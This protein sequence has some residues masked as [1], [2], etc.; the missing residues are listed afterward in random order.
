MQGLPRTMQVN[1]QYDDV[2]AEVSGFLKSRVDDLVAKGLDRQTL[3]IDPGIGFG[4]TDEH[5]LQLLANLKSLA[6]LGLPVVVGLSRKSFLGK[7]TGCPV[8]K[9]LAGSLAGLTFCA[10]NGAH[11]MR[12]HDVK[13]SYEA[14]QVAYALKN[15]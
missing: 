10:L 5:N 1:P 14:M 3:A 11:V 15:I 8:E 2:V 13:E 9:R 4:K 6:G 7:L 12:V